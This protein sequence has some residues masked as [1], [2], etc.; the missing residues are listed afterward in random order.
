MNVAIRH[1]FLRGSVAYPQIAL[2]RDIA[3]LSVFQ[4][5]A[6][7]EIAWEIARPI[8]YSRGTGV[9]FVPEHFSRPTSTHSRQSSPLAAA[10][11]CLKQPVVKLVAISLIYT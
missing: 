8:I 9:S 6:Y 5:L 11:Q 10:C 1:N 4:N 3:R 2:R 7:H